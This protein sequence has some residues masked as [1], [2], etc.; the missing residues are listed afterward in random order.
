MILETVVVSAAAAAMYAGS[1]FAKKNLNPAN[2]QE[3][4]L[5]K[6]ISTIAV[7]AVIGGI[8]GYYGVVPTDTTIELQLVT[9]AGAIAIVENV[10]KAIIRWYN[11]KTSGKVLMQS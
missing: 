7:G 2:P 4:D 10:S 9:Y 1:Q 11:S 6:F 3:F 5:V 8:S